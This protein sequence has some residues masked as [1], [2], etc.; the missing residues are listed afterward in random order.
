MF[1]LLVKACPFT[2]MHMFAFAFVADCYAFF[3][4]LQILRPIS[5][6]GNAFDSAV[7]GMYLH[8]QSG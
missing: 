5:T 1:T 4:R 7:N 2:R 3:A 8:E 6:C